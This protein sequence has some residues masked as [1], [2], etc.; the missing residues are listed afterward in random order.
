MS[1]DVDPETFLRLKLSA[2][3]AFSLARNSIVVWSKSSPNTSLA[4]AF[5]AKGINKVN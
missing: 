1:S 2:L 5:H 3:V 4:H